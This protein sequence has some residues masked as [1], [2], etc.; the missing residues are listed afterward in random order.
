M[1][2]GQV[3]NADI[4]SS[5]AFQALSGTRLGDSPIF[6]R[7]LVQGDEVCIEYQLEASVASEAT[8]FGVGP[9]RGSSMNLGKSVLNW[10]RAF[11]TE[12]ERANKAPTWSLFKQQ[13]RT[14]FRAFDFEYDLR[15]RMFRLKQNETIH[16]YVSKFQDLLSQTEL[17]ISELE[18]RFFF[19]NGLREETAKKIKEESPSTTA[20]GS[21]AGASTTVSS[22]ASTPWC[23]DKNCPGIVGG[24]AFAVMAACGLLLTAAL[25]NSP[26]GKFFLHRTMVSPPGKVGHIS[27]D[28]SQPKRTEAN[29]Y[30]QGAVYAILEAEAR[31]FK[32]EDQERPVTIFIDNGSS[33]NGVTEEL[34]KKLEL[35]VTE[36]DMMQVDLG[37]DHIVKF[38]RW[39]GLAMNIAVIIHVIQASDVV[40]VTLNEKYGECLV[41]E[42]TPKTGKMAMNVN[43]GSYF[44]VRL[45]AVSA[46]QWHPF[47]SIV[48]PDGKSLGFCIK[49]MGNGSF[50]RKLLLIRSNNGAKVLIREKRYRNGPKRWFKLA[51][52]VLVAGGVGIT[53]MMSLINQTRLFPNSTNDQERRT[54]RIDA[55]RGGSMNSRSFD[56]CSSGS[57]AKRM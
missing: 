37:Y 6:M 23:D 49:A 44:L 57:Q 14:R 33:L 47:S 25:K 12:C 7:A 55:L 26:I 41:L 40:D 29:R 35:D 19:Q 27:P 42:A 56:P 5:A 32:T 34:V 21:N 48:T 30:M 15:E 3:S 51:S 16:E 28:C 38:H 31:A 24:I 45:P 9:S 50:T 22:S 53:P 10:Y 11:I 13:L 17:A 39:L 46:T 1:A 2:S 54:Q 8:W 18:K 36:G 52:F 20:T 43:P 4:C